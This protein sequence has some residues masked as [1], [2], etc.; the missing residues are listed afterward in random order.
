MRS[1]DRPYFLIATPTDLFSPAST[2]D[3]SPSSTLPSKQIES[4]AAMRG[5][6]GNC[7]IGFAAAGQVFAPRALQM[8]D[9][10]GTENESTLASFEHTAYNH[11]LSFLSPAASF[12]ATP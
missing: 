4:F 6:C 3:A 9:I 5:W 8:I 1:R 11:A 7:P 12:A 10:E 2:N